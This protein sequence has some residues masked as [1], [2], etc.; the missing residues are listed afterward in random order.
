MVG[1][2][3]VGNGWVGKNMMFSISLLMFSDVNIN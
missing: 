2:K 1:G 3:G